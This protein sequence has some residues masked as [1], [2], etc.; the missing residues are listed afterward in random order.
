LYI[1]LITGILA[2]ILKTDVLFERSKS[3]KWFFSKEGL[4]E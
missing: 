4:N 3:L 2:L 1:A